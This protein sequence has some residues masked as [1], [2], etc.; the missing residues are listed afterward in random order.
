MYVVE[1]SAAVNMHIACV[2]CPHHN[3][4]HRCSMSVVYI[5]TCEHFESACPLEFNQ[6][7]PFPS[8]WPRE[9][10]TGSCDCQEILQSEFMDCSGV[11]DAFVRCP[12][13]GQQLPG[14]RGPARGLV[15]QSDV[16]KRV[17]PHEQPQRCS[18]RTCGRTDAACAE[19]AS[20]YKRA[21]GAGT[22]GVTRMWLAGVGLLDGIQR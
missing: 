11:L 4:F 16:T 19:W 9:H 10:S 14:S 5:Q 22:R 2:L 15:P 17:R 18:T 20:R 3:M 6:H 7:L 8:R 21:D 1:T 12:Q 13:S